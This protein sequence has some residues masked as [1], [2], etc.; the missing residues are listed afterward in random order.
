MVMKTTPDR[1]PKNKQQK[2][3]QTSQQP[4]PDTHNETKQETNPRS[5]KFRTEKEREREREERK[6]K[7]K[8][9]DDN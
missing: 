9:P 5:L 8:E 1:F 6:R 4:P 7:K 3:N 2:L